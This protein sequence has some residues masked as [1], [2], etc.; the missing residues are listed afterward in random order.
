MKSAQDMTA[1]SND[2]IED[3]IYNPAH[4]S[5][6]DMG[7]N[8]EKDNGNHLPFFSYSVMRRRT[9]TFGRLDDTEDGF[10]LMI[11]ITMTDAGSFIEF[12]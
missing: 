2:P 6:D 3:G 8:Y 9:A 4:Q 7:C 10:P 1:Q 5:K 11:H 12:G